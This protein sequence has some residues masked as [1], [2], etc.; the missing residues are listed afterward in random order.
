M[1]SLPEFQA[2]QV[3]WR[4]ECQIPCAPPGQVEQVYSVYASIVNQLCKL[5]MLIHFLSVYFSMKL[6]VFN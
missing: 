2:Q 4:G 1:W 3:K 6:S 5:P